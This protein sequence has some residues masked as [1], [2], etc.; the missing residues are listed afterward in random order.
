MKTF[1]EFYQEAYQLDEFQI[2]N[3][4]NNPMVKK[5]TQNPYVQYGK[6]ALKN[7]TRVA[8][9][10]DVF[11]SSKSPLERVGAAY[12]IAKPYSPVT[13]APRVFNQGQMGSLVD[14]TARVIPGMTPNPKT[15]LAR[16][17]GTA[18]MDFAK[19][20]PITP[21]SK[22]VRTPNLRNIK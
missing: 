5:I 20:K 2:E 9:I 13:Y 14:K 22:P 11:D 16:R 6:S 7:L 3:P 19:G 4:L 8:N 10:P 18:L 1:K 21:S 17:A 15:D 12:G